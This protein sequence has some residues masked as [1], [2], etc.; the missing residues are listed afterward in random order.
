M[1]AL[2]HL[3]RVRH[4]SLE[5]TTREQAHKLVHIDEAVPIHISEPKEGLHS[6]ELE[7]QRKA[8]LRLHQRRL[9]GVVLVPTR[10]R[11]HRTVTL[12][13]LCRLDCSRG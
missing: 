13:R 10:R 2:A 3:R 9:E 4:D 1:R 6:F 12:R 8:L 7:L 11:R 5:C